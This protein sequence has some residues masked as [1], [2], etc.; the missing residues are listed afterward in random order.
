VTVATPPCHPLKD[1]SVKGMYWA[2]QMQ[3]GRRRQ[4][5]PSQSQ[6]CVL[7]KYKRRSE[8]KDMHRCHNWS[9]APRTNAK[10]HSAHL[11]YC[12]GTAP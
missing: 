11:Y 12:T 4:M 6:I 9:L 10:C 5:V 7:F 1:V 8:V 2:W 3:H